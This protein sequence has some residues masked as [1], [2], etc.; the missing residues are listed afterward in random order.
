MNSVRS[1]AL[2]SLDDS[3]GVLAKSLGQLKAAK[4][5]DI[6]EVI[7]QL[8]MVAE[9]ARIVRESL[10]SELPDASWQNREELDALIE[11]IQQALDARASEQLR[12]SLLALAT[13]LERGSIV[14]RRT[15]RVN[16]LMHF[17]DKAI[18]E[19]RSQ[20]RAEGAP[21]ALPGPQA[22]QWIEWACGLKEPQD[23]ESL[24]TLRSGF[25]QLDDFVANLEPHMWIAG[26][27]PTL[28]T[29]PEPERST[30]K[31]QQE[32]P[33]P[34]TREPEDP[35][36]TSG[37][38]VAMKGGLDPSDKEIVDLM[39]KE[40]ETQIP[41][42]AYVTLSTQVSNPQKQF[43]K[44][45]LSPP[46]PATSS[47]ADD[48]PNRPPTVEL[49]ETTLPATPKV[50]PAKI[51]TA[52]PEEP[53]DNPR[54]TISERIDASAEPSRDRADAVTFETFPLFRSLHWLNLSGQC[55]QAPWLS[56][57]FVEKVKNCFVDSLLKCNFSHMWLASCTLERL[58]ARPTLPS[59][60]IELLHKVWS[61]GSAET[62]SSESERADYLRAQLE[63]LED[64]DTTVLRVR[65]FLA[66]I[67]P[68][69]ESFLS[70][71]EW[72][73]LIQRASFGCVPLR[74]TIAA[75]LRLSQHTLDPVGFVRQRINPDQIE[76]PED[77][78]AALNAERQK[79]HQL[80]LQYLN[81]AGGK[82]QRTHC[83]QAWSSFMQ[84]ISPQLQN[85]YPVNRGGLPTWDPV[86]MRQH[87]AKWVDLFATIMHQYNAKFT[88]LRKM[89]RTAQLLADGAESVNRTF[90]RKRVREAQLDLPSLHL[91][92]TDD[93][94]AL[95]NADTLEYP[96]EELCRRVLDRLLR[97][98]GRDDTVGMDILLKE[99]VLH[100]ELLGFIDVLPKEALDNGLDQPLLRVTT[101]EDPVRLMAYI[102]APAADIQNGA[103]EDLLDVLR[104]LLEDRA[105]RDLEDR[106]AQQL[107]EYEQAQLHTRHGQII[108][109][110][111]ERVD[112][113]RRQWQELDQLAISQSTQVYDLLAHVRT[114]LER[115]G[116]VGY[117]IP[118]IDAWI[119]S[120]NELCTTLRTA[121]IEQLQTKRANISESL[122][123]PFSNAIADHRYSDAMLIL[124]E[125]RLSSS[126]KVRETSWRPSAAALWA[127]PCSAIANDPSDVARAWSRGVLGGGRQQNTDK[128]LRNTFTN[129]VFSAETWT[130]NTAL[131]QCGKSEA[132]H[133]K[134]QSQ[135]IR[136][137]ITFQRINPTYLP[138]LADFN[139]VVV[140]TPTIPTD[141][142]LVVRHIIDQVAGYKNDL[143][144]VL[145]PKLSDSKRSELLYHALKKKSDSRVAIINDLD[146][147]RLIV[148]GQ[149]HKPN[150]LIGLFEIVLE[151]QNWLNC[152]PF[153][154]EDGQR[155]RME[156]FVGRRNEARDLTM[157]KQFSRVFSGR[158]LGKSAL[159]K[160]IRQTFDG[161]KMPS[162]NTLHVIYIPIV[163]A[164]SDSDIVTRILDG[165]KE[166]VGWSCYDVRSGSPADRLVRSIQMF[167]KENPTKSALL[168]LDEADNF[169]ESELEQYREKHGKCIS[170]RMRSEIEEL[171]DSHG[172]PRV[173]F[174]FSGYRQ[175]NLNAGAW[176]NWGDVLRLTP[177]DPEDAAS[178]V[179]GPLARLGI[180]ATQHA[181]SIA[182]RCGYQ[183]A[184][185]LRVGKLLLRRIH[186]QRSTNQWEYSQVTSDDVAAVFSDFQV[187][188]EIR[189]VVNNNFTQNRRGKII[190][191]TALLELSELPFGSELTDP[192]DRILERLE[193]I[194]PNKD[195]AW[196]R[197]DPS[198]EGS[199]KSEIGAQLR[200]LA[201]RQLLVAVREG[202]GVAY[203]LRFPHHLSV[204]RPQDQVNAI[205][206]EIA[207]IRRT[208]STAGLNITTFSMLSRD[209][210]QAFV[211]F[212]HAPQNERVGLRALVACSHWAE[213]LVHESGGIPDLLR[214]EKDSQFSA[215]TRLNDAVYRRHNLA[216]LQCSAQAASEFL[217]R[218][219]AELPP[220]L[221]V[222]GADLLRWS[223]QHR[224]ED[225]LEIASMRRLKL[226]DLSWW[227][228]RI[229]GLDLPGPDSLD[230]ILRVTSGIPILVSGVDRILVGEGTGG[231]SISQAR[232]DALLKTVDDE[233]PR[234]CRE[235]IDGPPSIRLTNRELE[236]MRMVACVGATKNLLQDLTEEYWEALYSSKCPTQAVTDGDWLP[237]ATLEALGIIPMNRSN[238]GLS[239]LEALQSIQ[240]G[241][242]LERM[243]TNLT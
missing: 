66:S 242:A 59:V 219:S 178:L 153:H 16:E 120:V 4:S 200:E 77:L 60:D 5:V 218:R 182:Y 41:P 117:E 126:A 26:G 69:A 225:F 42:H 118:L 54:T 11:K 82:V 127:D 215:L 195:L 50:T 192:E 37:S 64:S 230:R 185:I 130:A 233:F 57:D 105:R 164:F 119:T 100:P 148:P 61:S 212:F 154:T 149:D 173:R 23:A 28:E 171:T 134:I 226:H 112:S 78:E 47:G 17:R 214:V 95:L 51:P 8:K 211:E 65:C 136:D 165:I 193:K 197:T 15:H 174:V 81:A 45:S 125:R 44:P 101:Q 129:Y 155:I 131:H 223:L 161:E 91:I 138:Q 79:F 140:L 191:Y 12:S 228:E 243:I 36:A 107:S 55:E 113:L 104:S 109:T 99:A 168:V 159:L 188:D 25:A 189:Q 38:K 156:M 234:F 172:H 32:Q 167:V 1:S 198:D 240:V 85:L 221:V 33:R 162:G 183:P 179:E 237:I 121:A 35:V 70:K 157:Y 184:V 48:Q 10:S 86:S 175:T 24:Q 144:I 40:M 29:L 56:P 63:S 151:Q 231:I 206:Q 203:R 122:R 76:K 208:G 20:A 216:I 67:H 210:A 94:L 123:E 31:T 72:E 238:K 152:D 97:S 142:S 147:C 169:V 160:F 30:D 39:L 146:L 213:P 114:T 205:Q 92:P 132:T 158:K 163:G 177:L 202:R 166:A 6:A 27:P 180:D 236:I 137:C 53:P 46:S 239:A 80:V 190:F 139:S 49:R 14:H 143:C 145:A 229:R 150:P 88:D 187:Q 19:L 58:N 170:F 84:A 241:D 106:L 68:P 52:S 209:E 73:V 103:R 235:L 141:N 124:G 227:F 98:H 135:T 133:Y 13:E 3:L 83:R 128:R 87:I 196:L 176:A 204:L 207:A 90:E 108:D 111:Q 9:S 96:D 93:V 21:Q 7:E 194:D 110:L 71:S 75:L 232:F 62:V 115:A 74:N 222:G 89:E 186:D 224:V 43:L 2:K 34:E 18:N 22:D 220:P 116:S 102:L 217:S 199:A 201:Q 181:G